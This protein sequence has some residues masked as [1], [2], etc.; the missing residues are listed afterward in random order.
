MQCNITFWKKWNQKGS[1]FLDYFFENWVNSG[2]DNWYRSSIPTGFSHTNNG[3]EGFN[4]GI[5]SKYTDWEKLKLN[6]FFVTVRGII[7]DYSKDTVTKEF[8]DNVDTSKELWIKAQD[9][10]N[11][12]FFKKNETNLY[13]CKLNGARNT[14]RNKIT[15]GMLDKFMNFKEM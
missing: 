11:D 7:K 9:M 3:I 4:N 12:A 14:T 6:D 8:P 2:C 15:R 13:W 5:K 1:E 10:E